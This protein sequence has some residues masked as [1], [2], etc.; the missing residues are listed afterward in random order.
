MHVYVTAINPSLLKRKIIIAQ[1]GFSRE[2]ESETCAYSQQ[3][4]EADAPKALW[5]K[6][7]L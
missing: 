2:G 5:G 1:R 4:F 6:A 7:G 3:N